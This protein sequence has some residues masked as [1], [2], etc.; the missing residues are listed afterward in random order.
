MAI[1]RG[2]EGGRLIPV[3]EP[4]LKDREKQLLAECIDSGW[5]SSE[6]PFVKEFEEQYAR[7]IGAQHGVAVC[8]GT[9]ALETALYGIGVSKGDEIIM[10][11]FTII[12]CA[13]AALRLGA[14]LVLVDIDPA[15]WNMDTTQIES[16]VT[17]RTKAIMPVHIY[18]LPVDMDPV[19]DL[20]AQYD[21]KIVEDAAEAHGAE[22]FSRRAGNYWMKCGNMSDVGCFSFYANKIVTTGEGGMV[23]T[24]DPSIATRAASYRNLCFQAERRFYHTELC[25]NF[26]MTNLQA[27]VGLAQLERIEETIALRRSLA[28]HYK[29]C[30]ADVP[31]VRF[32]AEPAYAKPVYWMYAIQLDEAL[33]VDAE[34][35]MHELKDKGIGS[36]A[37]FLGLHAQP[38]LRNHSYVAEGSFPH[39]DQAHK[40]GLYLPSGLTLTKPQ[41]DVV[42][43]AVRKI[44]QEGENGR[45]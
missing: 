6:G 19:F 5:V 9:A 30:M 22:Y 21:L 14:R 41:I 38:V 10:P 1:E 45:I 15:T 37:F 39:T 24:N 42:C 27:A 31:G 2:H 36:R 23:V 43:E 13:L 4:L 16:K 44:I 17:S 8:N 20:A 34:S 28:A 18:G 29:K 35:M 26:R 11:S 32:Q 3:Y 12:S 33:G 25:Y 7:Y 40:Q